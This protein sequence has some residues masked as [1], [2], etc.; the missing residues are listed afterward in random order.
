MTATRD[1]KA[2]VAGRTPVDAETGANTAT[3]N[4]KASTDTTPATRFE[5]A[6]VTG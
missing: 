4:E 2:T 5:K 6:T 1:E 3:M